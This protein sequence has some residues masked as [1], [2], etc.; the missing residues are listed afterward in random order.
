VD[1]AR[2]STMV[3]TTIIIILAAGL[4]FSIGAA[5]NV[6]MQS[7][8]TAQQQSEEI[9]RIQETAMSS[10]APVAHTGNLPHAE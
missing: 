10:A 4:V 5:S 7:Q 9:Y 6:G 3:T 2:A 8:A 1:K